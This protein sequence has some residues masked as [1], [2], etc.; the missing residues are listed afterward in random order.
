MIDA[1][2]IPRLALQAF[3]HCHI[4]HVSQE[5]HQYLGHL[6]RPHQEAGPGAYLQWHNSALVYV[7]TLQ[8]MQTEKTHDTKTHTFYTECFSEEAREQK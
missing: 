5:V 1:H 8:N 6:G 4:R 7:H 3:L 2:T